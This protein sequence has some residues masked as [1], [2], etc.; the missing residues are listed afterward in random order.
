MT[1]HAIPN[2]K[3]IK[4]NGK[5]FWY[6]KVEPEPR[7]EYSIYLCIEDVPPGIDHW[8]V[9][10]SKIK[11]NDKFYRGEEWASVKIFKHGNRVYVP[12]LKSKSAHYGEKALSRWIWQPPETMPISLADKVYTV[13]GIEMELLCFKPRDLPHSV[14]Y[15]VGLFKADTK[16]RMNKEWRFK[17]ESELDE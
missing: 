12:I 4:E 15:G 7:P 9:N 17:Y 14:P 10:E 11:I 3:V 13:V 2:L 5:L 6:E 8:Q 16:I 1:S